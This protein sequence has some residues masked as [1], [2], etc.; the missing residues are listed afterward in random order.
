ELDRT[1]AVK[2][3]RGSNLAHSEHVDR[4]LREGRSVAGLNHPGIVSLYEAGRTYDGICYLVEEFIEGQTLAAR[5]AE[6][7]LG[8]RDAARL[9]AEVADALDYAHRHGVIHRDVKPSNIMLDE[10]ARAH[11][12]DFGLAKREAPHGQKE[13]PLTIDG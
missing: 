7:R 13:A 12:M 2:I 10:S 4:F 9:I 3:L 1:V 11:L 6:G 8:F 5:L